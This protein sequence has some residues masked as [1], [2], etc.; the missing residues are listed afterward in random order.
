MISYPGT[1]EELRLSQTMMAAWTSFARN[2]NPNAPG[3]PEW[4]PYDPDRRAV[5]DFDLESRIVYKP[6]EA[7]IFFE[8]SM[9]EKAGFSP[10]D[11]SMNK[12]FSVRNFDW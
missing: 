9:N 2:G 5:M 7:I 3:L 6:A 4:I 8:K 1:A 12:L 10:S 11:Y